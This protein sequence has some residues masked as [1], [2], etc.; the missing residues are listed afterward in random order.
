MSDY[1]GERGKAQLCTPQKH[2]DA[3]HN[4]DEDV[5]MSTGCV[6]LV[7]HSLFVF[8]LLIMCQHKMRGYCLQ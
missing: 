2:F 3:A 1:S 5:I 4:L 8:Q 7:V 6:E